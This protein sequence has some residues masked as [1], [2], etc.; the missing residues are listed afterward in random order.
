M[1]KLLIS[2]LSVLTLGVLGGCSKKMPTGDLVSLDYTR[3]GTV[4]GYE[5]EGHVLPDSTGGYIIRSMK[6][7]YGPLYEKKV[8]A[9]T[10]AKLREL[11]ELEKMYAYKSSCQPT[12]EVLDGY[13]WHF[14]ATFS[15][16]GEIDSHGSNAWPDG[17]GLGVIHA[18]LIKF[19]AGGTQIDTSSSED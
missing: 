7:N 6:E 1:R 12:F 11:I 17:G 2:I 14:H 10:V 13:S 3:S 16:G 19:V 18:F 15:D 5:Y 4:A 8:D 9:E